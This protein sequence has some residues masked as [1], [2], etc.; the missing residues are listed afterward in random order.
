VYGATGYYVTR[1]DEIADAVSA[2]LAAR[3][4][5]IVEIA[6]EE[7]FPTAAPTPGAG[8]AGH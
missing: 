1:P 7:Y 4:P 8:R 6:V 3:K 2:A 5:A